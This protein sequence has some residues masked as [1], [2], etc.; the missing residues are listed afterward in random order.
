MDTDYQFLPEL[1]LRAPYYSFSGY[2]LGR[3]PEVL[4]TTVFR[5]AIYLASPDFYR[6]LE[7]KE[8]DFNRLGQKEKHTL[9]KY[10]NRMCFRPTPFGS[11][12]SFTMLEWGDGGPIKLAGEE[13]ALLH[14]L[15]DGITRI[16][17]RSGLQYG[18]PLMLNPSLYKFEKEYRYV[19]STIDEKG[20]YR[21][22]LEALPAEK[23]YS[24]LFGWLKKNALR[25]EELVEKI[26]KWS[27]CTD[28]AAIDYLVFLKTEQVLFDES[29]GQIIG[30]S[31]RL[32]ETQL[33]KQC[34]LP[35]V[36]NDNS[37]FYAALERK[38]EKGCLPKEA[39]TDLLEALDVLRRLSQPPI[40]ADLKKFTVEFKERFDLEKVP[41]LLALDP[42]TG[43]VYGNN[44]VSGIDLEFG[45]IRFPAPQN[46][47]TSIEWQRTHALL[48]ELWGRARSQS[49]YAPVVIGKEDLANFGTSPA[50]VPP[51]TVAVMFRTTEEHL[52]VEY[53][54]G[55]SGTSLI[56]R[57]SVF[58]E[59]AGQLCEKLA[60]IESAANPGIAFA[61]IGQLS[62]SHADNINRRQNIFPFQIP[63]N[64]YPG[65]QTGTIIPLS[66]ILIS[67]Q[68]GELV[69]ESVKLKRRVIP[70]LAT[71][72]NYQHNGLGLF[73]LLCDLQYQGVHAI[74]GL[75]YETF[76]PGLSFYPRVSSGNVVLCLAKWHF[77]EAELEVLRNTPPQVALH[78]V[79]IFRHTYGLPQRVSMGNSDQQLVFDLAVQEEVL[80]FIQCLQ[81]VKRLTLSEYLLPGKIIK[82]GNK[83][84]AGQFVAFLAHH[85]QIYP[86]LPAMP[87]T[88]RTAPRNFLL[89]GEWLF[90]KIYCTPESADNLLLE[91]ITPLIRKK[92]KVIER[93]FF[94]RYYENGHHL[95][96]R[97]K[98]GE[99]HIGEILT[100][101]KNKL[102]KPG[103][104]CL[105]RN[106]QGDTY[107]RELE[108][109]G[110]A[111]ISEVESVFCSGSEFAAAHI[112]LQLRGADTPSEF[113]FGLLN[114]HRIAGIFISN[115][116]VLAE[117]YKQ[118]AERFIKGF[119]GDKQ[120]RIQL[121]NKY[122]A[123]RSEIEL[124]LGQA[125]EEDI[126][127]KQFQK[128]RNAN[129][130]LAIK[131]K[132]YK[133]EDRQKLLA[134]L[135]HMQLNRTFKIKQRVQ[136]MLVYYFLGK[137]VASKIARSNVK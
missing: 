14:L 8:F 29:T 75:S 82:T 72:Y 34:L 23:F 32:L 124:L 42:D 47:I 25:Q 81:N 95:R 39:Q 19:K 108:R 74:H 137:Y 36:A 60:E 43:I 126:L 24:A 52:V 40:P 116:N 112:A 133:N 109:Y 121:D 135:I 78:Q 7:T 115:P 119:A 27:G 107:R 30:D 4:A 1:F 28:A 21:F 103:T 110:A 51:Q 90:L 134:D 102:Q 117:F 76:F 106:Y 77:Q 41:L 62:H 22:S 15:P 17:L 56:G 57:F 13:A 101:L 64:V 33:L 65:Q 80:F 129:L 97:I 128:F 104:N 114:T 46:N 96:L 89:G 91:V 125:A 18:G 12:A 122:R 93:W 68:H 85:H 10:Y 98:T 2:D 127:F 11:F 111:V 54:G 59:G 45:E 84:L 113:L 5:N 130:K 26:V 55:A 50:A 53:T 132:D 16:P 35:H 6:V 38:H 131:I 92:R 70:R 118:T 44:K 3:L 66:D 120:L 61:D 69:M 63:V 100:A 136:E 67:V 31:R 71:A 105:V 88:A 9:Y 87:P 94:I 20:R 49:R 58:N 99:N 48:L 79:R 83:P 37:T 123:S 73:R 86:A